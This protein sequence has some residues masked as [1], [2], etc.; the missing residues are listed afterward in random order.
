MPPRL[1]SRQCVELV[2]LG[3]LLPWASTSR[4]ITTLPNS[5]P[6]HYDPTSNQAESS[7]MASSRLTIHPS[8]LHRMDQSAPIPPSHSQSFIHAQLSIPSPPLPSTLLATLRANPQHL[9][10]ASGQA[11]S[12]YCLRMGDLKSYRGVWHL[13]G[14]MRIA[15]ISLNRSCLSFRVPLISSPSEGSVKVKEKYR[16]RPNRWAFKM[17]P[18]LRYLPSSKY[19]SQDLLRHLHY[20]LLNGESPSLPESSGLIRC[21]VDWSITGEG[22]KEGRALELL[23]LHLAYNYKLPS[24]G[25]L[26]G[27]ELVDIYLK[28]FPENRVNRQTLHLMAKSYISPTLPTTVID[29]QSTPELRPQSPELIQLKNKILAIISHFSLTHDIIPGPETYRILAKFAAYYKL[30]DV[31]HLAWKGWYD[32]IEHKEENR[33]KA[34]SSLKGADGLDGTVKIRFNRIG[35][36]NKRWTRIVKMYENLGWVKREEESQEYV[37]VGEMGRLA[38]L[39]EAKELLAEEKVVEGKTGDIQDE[40]KLEGLIKQ[41]EKEITLEGMM[42]TQ[43]K[44]E[45]PLRDDGKLEDALRPIVSISSSQAQNVHTENTKEEI[46]VNISEDEHSKEP[47]LQIV[48]EEKKNLSPETTTLPECPIASHENHKPPYFVLI[49]D[50]STV[51]I[52]S[53]SKDHEIDLEGMDD[54]PIW[55]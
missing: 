19:T 13:I 26:D 2:Q 45:V 41:V 35:H 25:G 49:R 9:T 51:K 21:S 43:T 38:V 8:D 20:L 11:L 42:N 23:N 47:I 17:F 12:A 14:K 39:N 40:I 7:K 10:L 50:G 15:P 37:W 44:V 6:Y 29:N 54:K 27:L 55:E 36:M 32:A 33:M 18:P 5:N 34:V 53:K 3:F 28:Q 24:E 22:A 4:S 1:P 30:E 16:C 52:R 46:K 31:A 48:K